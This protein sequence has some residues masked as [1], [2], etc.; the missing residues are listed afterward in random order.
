[1][2][3]L[4]IKS[5]SFFLILIHEGFLFYGIT[6]VLFVFFVNNFK[7]IKKIL[8]TITF[9]T[10]IFNFG[11]FLFLTSNYDT[12][13]IYQIFENISYYEKNL[14][15]TAEYQPYLDYAKSSLENLEMPISNLLLVLKET[16]LINILIIVYFTLFINLF[17]ST[18]CKLNYE[19]IIKVNILLLFY[20][21]R[22][23]F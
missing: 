2:D 6:F 14:L 4:I 5:L 20:F 22:I 12:I 23:L 19:R 18:Y 3:I 9:T 17:I 16:S 13:N 1:M 8:L 11:L 7:I 10:Y 21:C 15:L